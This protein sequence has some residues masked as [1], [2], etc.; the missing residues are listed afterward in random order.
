MEF[1]LNV[2]TISFFFKTNVYKFLL[3]IV[4]FIALILSV[5]IVLL[6]IQFKILMGTVRKI[7]MCLIVIFIV[8]LKL[9]INVKKV[10]TI[11]KELAPS[12]AAKAKFLG[13]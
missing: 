7:L 11:Q 10:I 6:L 5:S 13:C 4:I 1:V 12:P 8:V 2:M 3:K 9:V